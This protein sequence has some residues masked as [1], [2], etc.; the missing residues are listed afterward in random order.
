MALHNFYPQELCVEQATLTDLDGTCPNRDNLLVYRRGAYATIATLAAGTDEYSLKID[1]GASYT[2]APTFIGIVDG[3]M[4]A[5]NAILY[6]SSDGTSWTQVHSWL[7]SNGTVAYTFAAPTAR[8]YY[9]LRLGIGGGLQAGISTMA[10]LFLGLAI[11]P[12]LDCNYADPSERDYSGTTVNTSTGGNRFAVQRY[13]GRA[14]QTL[15]YD[16]LGTTDKNL[17]LSVDTATG[18][19]LKPLIYTVDEGGSAVAKYGR[20]LRMM[21]PAE[22]A[23]GLWRTTLYLEEEL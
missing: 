5:G 8:R 20:L 11:T 21:Q 3:V 16:L 18:G 17:L 10:C 7:L 2:L 15:S 1:L 14:P 13:A 19:P 6:N 4:V 22:S 12:S 9:K 23:S